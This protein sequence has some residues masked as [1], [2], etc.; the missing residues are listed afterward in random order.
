MC[1]EILFCTAYCFAILSNEL[2]RKVL[3]L[4]MLYG[5]GITILLIYICLISALKLH[6]KP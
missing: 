1:L 3:A 5:T 6:Q 2:L 4:K